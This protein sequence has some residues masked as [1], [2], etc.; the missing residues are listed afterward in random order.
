MRILLI[1]P[2]SNNEI[3]ANTPTYV[4]EERGFN[5]PLG[6]L[7]LA[8]YLKQHS[9]HHVFGLD[10]QAERLTYDNQFIKRI[11]QMSPELVGITAMTF[12]MI[13]VL[14]TIDLIKSAEKELNKR[15][16]IVLGGPHVHLF[17]QETINLPGVDYLIKGE[18]EKPFF[19]L[20]EALEKN[21]DISQINGLVF[22][23]DNQ[24]IDNPV[25][26]LINNLDEIPFPDRQLLPIE[27]YNSVLSNNRIVT[28]M[29]TSRGCPFQCAF[30][31]RPHLGKKFRAR[32]AQ[33]VVDEMEECLNLGIEEILVYDDT[34]T[35][36][37]QRTLDI[38]DEILKR[39]L[40]FV[41]DIRARVDTVDKEILEKLKQAGCDRIHFGVE[42][43][44][45]KILKVLNKGIYLD[46]VEQTFKQAKQVGIE[47]LAY[48][49]IG[50][51]QETRE[52]INQT[53]QFAKKI[54]PDYVSASVLTPYPATQVYEWALRDG[55]IKYDYWKEFAKSPKKGV[56]TKYW[57]KELTKEE[58]FALLDK[59]YKKFYGRPK[60]VF[61]ELLKVRS[62]NDLIKKIKA[63]FKILYS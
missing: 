1:N 29:F 15:I 40:K 57:E 30:C 32:S 31:D 5:P 6:L 33:N 48:F 56:N 17:P 45:E 10:A 44:T 14:K 27:K 23:Q 28:T 37:K 9:Q 13:D 54:D 60:Y 43:G 21:Q 63:G 42:A 51:P 4:S 59:F 52:D 38:C 20:L 26:Q 58:L 24:V 12:T 50:S 46:Q 34:F 3:L 39:N 41:W 62:V 8:G 7:Y 49:M 35:V 55:V 36:N 11:L 2:S 18:G 53:I 61:K 19:E 47:R 25:N 22:K 16:K